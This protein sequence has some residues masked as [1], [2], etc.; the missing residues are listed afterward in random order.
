ML[1]W[2][3]YV[4]KPRVPVNLREIKVEAKPVLLNLNL[5]PEINILNKHLENFISSVISGGSLY[6][7]WER[8]AA[9]SPTFLTSKPHNLLN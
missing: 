2:R 4:P 6:R 7:G 8:S 3:D 9:M 5:K 1:H